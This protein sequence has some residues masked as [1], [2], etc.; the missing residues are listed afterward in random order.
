[1]QTPT[2]FQGLRAAL[3]AL[4]FESALDGLDVALPMAKEQ[5]LAHVEWIAARNPD[6]FSHRVGRARDLVNLFP[7]WP[8]AVKA[9]QTPIP[10]PEGTKQEVFTPPKKT[11]SR[12]FSVTGPN[13]RKLTLLAEVEA[14]LHE[15]EALMQQTVRHSPEHKTIVQALNDAAKVLLVAP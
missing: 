13:G 12:K 1:M 10:A 9:G 2:S 11:G 7:H 14:R 4:G 5:A 15:V 3:K 8:G 6:S